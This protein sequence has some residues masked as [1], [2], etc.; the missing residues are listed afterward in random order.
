ML[1]L[2]E[3]KESLRF[4][5]HQTQPCWESSDQWN[6]I[7]SFFFFSQF[8]SIRASA[9]K[10][11]DYT[12]QDQRDTLRISE[13][14]FR[15]SS[16]QN[17]CQLG[18]AAAVYKMRQIQL[19]R[20]KKYTLIKNSEKPTTFENVCQLEQVAAAVMPFPAITSP[21]FWVAGWPWVSSVYSSKPQ[22]CRD[23]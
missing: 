18:L 16:F 14:Q 11:L 5:A 9:C 3:H 20:S 7:L 23:L 22:I 17:F 6:P 10:I 12:V 15:R 1:K 19:S 8:L 4:C 2:A 21:I 13:I